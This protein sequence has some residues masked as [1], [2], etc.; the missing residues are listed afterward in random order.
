MKRNESPQPRFE[1]EDERTY[2]LAVLPVHPEMKKRGK[3][4]GQGLGRAGDIL[5]KSCLMVPK[6]S[7]LMPEGLP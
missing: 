2:F 6:I 4:G 7:L 5:K 3:A 1:T